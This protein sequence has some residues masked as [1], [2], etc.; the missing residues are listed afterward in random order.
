MK[1]SEIIAEQDRE[2]NACL[3]EDMRLEAKA[4]AEAEALAHEAVLQAQAELEATKQEEEDGH[5]RLSP[6]SLRQQRLSFFSQK[7]L[8]QKVRRRLLQGIDPVNVRATRM[9]ARA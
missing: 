1:A 3:A 2:Y 8:P 4:A 5:N 9:R 7:Q 6:A